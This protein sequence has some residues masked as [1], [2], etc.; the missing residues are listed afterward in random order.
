MLGRDH[1]L[2]GA[3]VALVGG[4]AAWRAFGHPALPPGQLAAAA[5][6]CAAFAL[7]PDIDEPNSTV[8]RRL[9]PISA[10]VSS[11]TNKIAGGHRQATHSIAFIVGVWFAM[12]FAGEHAWADVITVG[13]S[14]ALVLGMLIP[15]R[16][17]RH[18]LVVG[19]VAPAVAAWGTWTSTVHHYGPGHQLDPVTWPWLAWAAAVGVALH[20]VGDMLTVEGVPLLWPIHWRQAVPLLGHTDSLREQITG[21]I[22]SLAVLGLTWLYVLSPIFSTADPQVARLIGHG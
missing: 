20:L 1:A 16:F 17:A 21:T 14:L 15:G 3:T 12:H 22:L 4:E 11:I 13:L 8:S 10:G 5:G 9:G 19:L 2:L 18:G 7:L 6:V